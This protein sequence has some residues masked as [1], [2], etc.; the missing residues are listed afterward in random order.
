MINYLKLL[1]K[2]KFIIVLALILAIYMYSDSEPTREGFSLHGMKLRGFG[3]K[4]RSKYNKAKRT[5][6][7]KINHDKKT[8]TEKMT[9]I[10]NKY[11]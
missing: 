3:G 1:N 11:L 6:K 10:K 8:I 9:S 4:I 7:S 2:Y 5:L